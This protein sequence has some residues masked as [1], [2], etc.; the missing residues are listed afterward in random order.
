MG[1]RAI[2]SK[3]IA[4]HRGPCHA[5]GVVFFARI[6]HPVSGLNIQPF[7]LVPGRTYDIRVGDPDRNLWRTL[8]GETSAR[9]FSHGGVTVEF[10]E[11]R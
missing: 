4:E 7:G 6:S 2:S 10:G 11:A 3:M 5:S 8:E 1:V 9:H